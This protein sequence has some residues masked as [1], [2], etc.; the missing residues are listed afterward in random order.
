MTPDVEDYRSMVRWFPVINQDGTVAPPGALLRVTGLNADGSYAVGKPNADGQSRLLINS[1]TPIDANGGYGIAAYETPF[2]AAYD[3]AD[4]T[5][6][7]GQGWGA[8]SGEWKLRKDYAGFVVQSTITTGTVD[9]VRVSPGDGTVTSVAATAPTAGFTITGGPITSSGTLVF[10]LADD[11]AALEALT[12]TN[13]IYYR[14]ASST[15]SVVTVDDPLTFA[16]G[17]LGLTLFTSPGI[18]GSSG[19]GPGGIVGLG[20]GLAFAGTPEKLN[21]GLTYTDGEASAGYAVGTDDTFEDTGLSITLAANAKWL[22]W[23]D[24]RWRLKVSSVDA[25]ILYGRA[26]NVTT[27]AA[28]ANTP[29]IFVRANDSNTT[30]AE[31]TTQIMFPVTTGGAAETIRLEMKRASGGTYVNSDMLSAADAKTKWR[32]LRYG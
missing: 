14:S 32:A 11:L 23:I 3:T 29:T 2:P 15:W 16:S 17:H 31:G 10:T 28:V 20:Y 5:P 8:K 6:A 27:A 26:Y 12:G 25:G 19:A 24:V 21:V 13:T 18:Y 30:P 7:A 22:V 9:V 4:G 1:I